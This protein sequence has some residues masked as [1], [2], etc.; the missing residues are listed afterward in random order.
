MEIK[1]ILFKT[2]LIV[3]LVTGT[4]SLV[5]AQSSALEGLLNNQTQSES[6]LLQSTQTSSTSSQSTRTSGHAAGQS[7]EAGAQAI[8]NEIGTNYDPIDPDDPNIPKPDEQDYPTT[9]T[10]SR[11]DSPIGDTLIPLV[12]LLCT[13]WCWRMMRKPHTVKNI[14]KHDQ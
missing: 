10:H 11:P 8:F 2:L 13:F 12:M 14:S 6:Q 4:R 1:R 7:T 5:T 3:M 9:Q